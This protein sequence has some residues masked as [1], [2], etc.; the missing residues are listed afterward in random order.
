MGG[1]RDEQVAVI[2][3]ACRL[4]GAEDE[5]AYW[6]LIRTGRCAIQR[7][8]LDDLAREGVSANLLNHPDFVPASGYLP[9]ADEFDAGFFGMSPK[10]A[11][12]KV[13]CPRDAHA[14]PI[15]PV[16][17][18]KR[19]GEHG[20]RGCMQL[21]ASKP[22]VSHMRHDQS[23]HMVERE[24]IEAHVLGNEAIGERRPHAVGE[25]GTMRLRHQFGRTRA[26]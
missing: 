23:T 14:V 9:H 22:H 11:E 15:D 1:S 4:P 13:G 10:E 3:L 26:P 5:S 2:G 8:S 21:L 17:P 19:R 18:A 20:G 7:Y 25:D 24:P 12:T 16:D 6:D